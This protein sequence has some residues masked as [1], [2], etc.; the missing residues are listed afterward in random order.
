MKPTKLVLCA[1]LMG[2]VALPAMADKASDTL[3]WATD[4]EVA[5]LDPYFSVT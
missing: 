5:V 4:K 2:A 1:A 3:N